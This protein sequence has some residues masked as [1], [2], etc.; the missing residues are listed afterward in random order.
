M[1]INIVQSPT[2][3]AGLIFFACITLAVFVQN[4]QL[5]AQA[6]KNG[7]AAP[8]RY[9]ALDPFMGLDYVIQFF[10]DVSV[11]QRNRL[12]YG[13]TFT[14]KPL[15]SQHSIVTSEPDNIQKVF[16]S[17]DNDYSVQWRRESFVPFTGRGI[18][19]EDGDGWRLPRKMYRPFFA[20][21]NLAKLEAYSK[22]VEYMLEKIPGEGKTVDMHPILVDGVSSTR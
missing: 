6:R 10:A 4:K 21:S 19:T 22:I 7:C 12:R 2:L 13:K 17:V 11:M 15:I 14:I 9:R 3:V 18:L 8:A 5:D 16:A 20:K 1:D